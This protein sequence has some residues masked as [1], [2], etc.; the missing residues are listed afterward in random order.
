MAAWFIL[1]LLLLVGILLLARAFT[2]A[3]PQ[4]LAQGVRAFVAGFSV[5]AGTGLLFT[6]RLGLALITLGAA[7]M[8]ARAM[9]RA[10]GGFGSAFGQGGGAAPQTSTVTTDTL[11]MELDRGTGEVEGDVLRGPF[12][13]RSLASLGISDLLSLLAWCQSEDPRS[14]ALLETYLDRREPSWRERDDGTAGGSGGAGVGGG[15]D[16]ATA[17]SILG[18]EPGAGPDE[19]KAAHRR[20]MNQFHPDHGGSGYLA[21]QINQAKDLLLRRSR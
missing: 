18:L 17:W 3:S 12:A 13:G 10:P 21:A 11:S 7:V 14:V 5:L 15:L 2:M 1:G 20:L 19:I 8:A 9:K 4:Q 6:G 16:E